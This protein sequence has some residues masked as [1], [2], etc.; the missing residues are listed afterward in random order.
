[1][2]LAYGFKSNLP[3]FPWQKAG[4]TIQEVNAQIDKDLN[5]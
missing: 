5:P 2:Y 1:M 3:K 4:Q